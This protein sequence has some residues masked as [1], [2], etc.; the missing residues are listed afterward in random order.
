[1]IR[2]KSRMNELSYRITINESQLRMTNIDPC[3]NYLDG[4][5]S[6]EE[7]IERGIL[8][9]REGENGKRLHWCERE[10]Q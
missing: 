5:E 2:K 4:I 3:S 10:E 9:I 6:I 7:G 8:M 1:M